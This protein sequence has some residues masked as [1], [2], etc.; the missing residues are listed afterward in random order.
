VLFVLI[1]FLLEINGRHYFWNNLYVCNPRQFLFTQ[2]GP[3]KSKGWT[4]TRYW[5]TCRGDVPFSHAI[6]VWSSTW[7]PL[8]L[9]SFWNTASLLCWP[10][11]FDEFLVGL[12]GCILSGYTYWAR[13]GVQYKTLFLLKALFNTTCVLTLLQCSLKGK[14]KLKEVKEKTQRRY[15]LQFLMSLFLGARGIWERELLLSETP[16]R[17]WE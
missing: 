17:M 13:K 10:K 6:S 9:V 12:K 14:Q 5:K 11:V 16:D 7:E 2:C 1:V 3:K 4:S 15:S 8:K